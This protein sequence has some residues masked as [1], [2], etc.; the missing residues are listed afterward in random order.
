M[1]SGLPVH[2]NGQYGLAHAQEHQA[3]FAG[4]QS[5]PNVLNA[6]SI[7]T[8]ILGK[9]HVWASGDNS[10]GNGGANAYNFSWGLRPSGPGGCQAGASYSCPDTDY[11]TVSRNITYMAQQFDAFLGYAGAAPFFFYVGFGDSHRCGGVQGEFCEKWGTPPQGHIPDWTPH[12]YDPAAVRLPFWVQ[13]T[14]VARADWANMYR[15]VNR[16]DQGIGLLL[17]RLRASGRANDTLVVFVADNGAPF[18]AGKTNFYEPGARE[19]LIISAPGVAGGARTAALA[20]T[21]DLM[22]TVLDWLRVPMP[23]YSLNGAPVVLHGRSLLPLMAAAAAAADAGA[24]AAGV[25]GGACLAAAPPRA[26]A[27]RRAAPLHE[28][29]RTAAEAAAAAPPLAARAPPPVL[30]PGYAT[31]RGSFIVHEIQEYYPMRMLI[32]SN[33]APARNATFR[34]KLIMNVAGPW[35]PYPIAADLFSA[36]AFV[37]LLNRTAA[38]E[39]THWYRN[40]SSYLAVPRPRYELYDLLNDAAEATNLAGDAAWASVLATLQADMKAWQIATSD[41]FVIKYTHE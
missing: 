14:P 7:T 13:D 3:A 21:L 18:A 20:S 9:Y 37:D 36:P 11:N 35:L 34:V 17:A 29:S 8:G 12:T 15:S 27:S 22:P 23:A 24:G 32:A 10:P 26:A 40:F 31:A 41:D 4:V 6:A 39:P 16:M 33:P 1:L 2:Q 19:P 25:D 30:P 38:G 5:L 28:L